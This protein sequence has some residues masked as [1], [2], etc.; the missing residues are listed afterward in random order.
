MFN[1]LK[2]FLHRF[3]SNRLKNTFILQRFGKY[4]F[5]QKRHKQQEDNHYHHRALSVRHRC[6]HPQPD[7]R[8]RRL[9][10]AW[11]LL[12]GLPGQAV[13]DAGGQ[14]GVPSRAGAHRGPV[15]IAG[16][17]YTPVSTLL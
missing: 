16:H 11:E 1:V 4:F 13:I 14:P 7:Q 9:R 12:S 15:Q 10:G 8:T 3:V 5:S 6:H 17:L 2:M